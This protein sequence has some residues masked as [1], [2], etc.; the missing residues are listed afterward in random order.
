MHTTEAQS[1]TVSALS[2]ALT[3]REWRALRLAILDRDGWQCQIRG[4]R[5]ATVATT[6]DHIVRP[7]DGGSI[8]N[9]TNLRAAC[10][11][12]NSR[13]GA[14]DGNAQRRR[15]AFTYRRMIP[16]TFTRW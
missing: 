11:P 1:V 5:C 15:A 9:E 3:S 14:I 7:D 12:C 6:V 8:W 10:R 13:R 16:Q 4:P 2:T